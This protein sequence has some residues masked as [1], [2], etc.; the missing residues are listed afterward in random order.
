MAW[1]PR[2]AGRAWGRPAGRSGS[3]SPRVL[4]MAPR[5]A[6]PARTG[7]LCDGVS[8]AW[9]LRGRCVVPAGSR[10]AGILLPA[11][12]GCLP[13][14]GRPQLRGRLW[15]GLAAGRRPL[16]RGRPPARGRLGAR[17]PLRARGPGVGLSFRRHRCASPGV[18]RRGRLDP[19]Q[20][21]PILGR[22]LRVGEQVGPALGSAAQRLLA[23]SARDAAVVA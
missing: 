22:E 23:A 9:I 21:T 12:G 2:A 14:S 5:A 7:K 13:G 10:I 17:P 1:R 15:S 16:R 3:S 19:R 8:C 4:Q 11:S 6:G 20:I 18:Y